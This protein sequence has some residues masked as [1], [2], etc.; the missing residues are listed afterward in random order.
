MTMIGCFDAVLYSKVPYS[1]AIIA[2]VLAV[3]DFPCSVIVC[4]FI[5]MRGF[6]GSFRTLVPERVDK[7]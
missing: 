4:S 6:F 3:A 1:I 7:F 5:A 2:I